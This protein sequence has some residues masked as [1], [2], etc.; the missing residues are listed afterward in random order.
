M[1]DNRENR[2]VG[3]GIIVT[4]LLALVLLFMGT[5][6]ITYGFCLMAHPKETSEVYWT[7]V[8]INDVLRS[9]E[10]RIIDPFLTT[11]GPLGKT[12]CCLVSFC[13]AGGDMCVGAITVAEGSPLSGVLEEYIGDSE[14]ALGG[15]I[16]KGYFSLTQ[17]DVLGEKFNA[18]FT[19]ACD[20][21]AGVLTELSSR[22]YD[23]NVRPTSLNF[24]YICAE[25]ENY[26]AALGRQDK[27][28]GAIGIIIAAAGLA[29]LGLTVGGL[30][31]RRKH[32]NAAK[33]PA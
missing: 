27:A 19:D 10:L 24:S 31:T 22:Y 6:L 26:L 25:N 28:A 7:D 8:K 12:T 16:V 29:G 15:F 1:A 9:D 20:K 17:T 32:A 33:D 23:G 11:D 13:D 21:Y 30:V 2:T 4:A 14:A 3:A 5:S 18:A